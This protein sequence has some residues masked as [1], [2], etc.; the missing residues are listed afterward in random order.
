MKVSDYG[1]YWLRY[2]YAT[3][4]GV[5]IGSIFADTK[6]AEILVSEE[7]L[8]SGIYY[9]IVKGKIIHFKDTVHQEYFILE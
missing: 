4:L 1:N 2:W 5:G 7:I 8:T 6:M 9:N 3:S